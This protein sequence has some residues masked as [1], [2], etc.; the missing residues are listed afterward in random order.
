MSIGS[1]WKI[2]A[3]AR[4]LYEAYRDHRMSHEGADLPSWAMLD[5]SKQERWRSV[6]K[7]A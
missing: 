7:A 2:E 5:S 3:K 1:D 4:R 6:A